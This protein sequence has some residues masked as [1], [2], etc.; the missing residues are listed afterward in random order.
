MPHV[1]ARRL[2]ALATAGDK[3]RD[4]DLPTIS[5]TLPG[6][7]VNQWYGVL[8]PAGTPPVILDRLHHEIV[9]A[10]ANP[11]VAQQFTSLDTDAVAGP[12]QEFSALIKSEIEKWAKVIKVANIRL[13]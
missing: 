7:H 13:D 3:R 11:K 1:T 8:A 6:Y 2:R 5:E 10:I 9:R 12:P 4:P